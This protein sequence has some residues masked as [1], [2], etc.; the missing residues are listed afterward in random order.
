MSRVWRSCV[1]FVTLLGVA[2]CGN[3][4]LVSAGVRAA[5]HAPLLLQPTLLVARV[6]AGKQ[7]A[8]FVHAPAFT[9]LRLS[10]TYPGG[11]SSHLDGTTDGQGRY[12]FSWVVPAN[13]RQSGTA[14]LQVIAQR[15][16]QVVHWLGALPVRKAYAPPLFVMPLVP[17][18]LAGTPVKIFVS[19]APT[20]PIS[21]SLSVQRG[22]TISRGKARTDARGRFVVS[23]P[24]RYLPHRAVVVLAT[25]TATTPAGART[26]QTRLT[27]LPRPPL[28]LT[29][30]LVHKAVRVGQLWSVQVS[31][32]P[33]TRVSLTVI[34]THT[35]LARGSGITNAKGRWTYT[36]AITTALTRA[37]AARIVVQ[38]QHGIDQSRDRIALLL[39]PGQPGIPDRLASAGNPSPDLVR[40][41]DTT[42]DK[43]IMVSVATTGQT[44][45]A[46]QDGVLV[47]ED[48]VTT[49]EPQLPTP[50]GIYHVQTKYA[51][52][53]FISPWP[54]GSPFYYPPS[55]THFAMLFREG[56]YF[57]HDAPWRAVYGPG[58]NL[59][60]AS[61]PGEPIG[62]HGCVNL[63]YPD[64][65]WL[66]NWTPIGTTVVVY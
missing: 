35:V 27:L 28:P 38:A 41:F 59:P 50:P 51:P 66:W 8:L 7:A 54:P 46:Y 9:Q 30:T 22:A 36:T 5:P 42:P 45:R 3:A 26:A 10:L 61:D 65:V 55:W 17:R 2:V 43:L 56:G 60:H 16:G 24:D 32:T 25:I 14:R 19:T 6:G 34:L 4:V 29:V 64:M 49:G 40:Y 33:R 62:T 39:Q 18:V 57:L 37:A 1:V 15:G 12:V 48:Y 63:P 52:Y 53:E 47:H 31:S 13:L 44:L 21:Y 23:V 58:T 20:T 11:A